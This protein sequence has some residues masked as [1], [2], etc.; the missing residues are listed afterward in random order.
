VTLDLD[1]YYAIPP[2]LEIEGANK[3]IIREWIKKLGLE[4]HKV[5]NWSARQTL[6]HYGQW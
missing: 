6:L 4:K 2:L 3:E 1:L 5:V